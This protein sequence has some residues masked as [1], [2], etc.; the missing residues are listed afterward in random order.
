MIIYHWWIQKLITAYICSTLVFL[1]LRL[2]SGQ[3]RGRTEGFLYAANGVALVLLFLNLLIT[4]VETIRCDVCY[5]IY[6]YSFLISTVLLGF[7]FQLCF[8]YK[9]HRVKV[10]LTVI[11]IILLS[12]YV[13]FD[14]LILLIFSA[15]RDYLP[16][17]WSTYYLS[18]GKGLTIGMAAIYFGVCWVWAGRRGRSLA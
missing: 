15:Y 9:K 14:D 10:S 11:S 6:F 2:F 12:I 1:L 7:L 17:V 4:A 13:N 18:P 3:V 8:L 5:G 16:S